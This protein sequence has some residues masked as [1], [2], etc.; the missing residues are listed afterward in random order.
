MGRDE[1]QL[2][3]ITIVLMAPAGICPEWPTKTFSLE[4]TT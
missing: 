1:I 2:L 4:V 3:S